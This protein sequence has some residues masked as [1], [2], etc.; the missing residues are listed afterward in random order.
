MLPIYLSV[1][2]AY[3][4][5]LTLLMLLDRESPN[6]DGAAWLTILVA[7]AL[8]PITIPIS[9]QEVRERKRREAALAAAAKP[10]TMSDGSV[11]YVKT[12]QATEVQNV[13]QSQPILSAEQST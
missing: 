12:I 13:P 10:A 5:F 7:C 1:S 2:A 3:G 8:W 4:I 9:R 6:N 11:R